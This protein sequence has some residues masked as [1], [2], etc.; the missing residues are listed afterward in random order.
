MGFDKNSMKLNDAE[1]FDV[2]DGSNNNYYEDY[3]FSD[4]EGST[5]S[6]GLN[7]DDGD[8]SLYFDAAEAEKRRKK[9]RAKIRAQKK[10][11]AQEPPPSAGGLEALF[12]QPAPPPRNKSIGIHGEEDGLAPMRRRPAAPL[13]TRSG[14]IMKL[15]RK[16][17]RTVTDAAR[18]VVDATSTV[19]E[20][21][22]SVATGRGREEEAGGE[23]GPRSSS[24]GAL[25]RRLGVTTR[26]ERGRERRAKQGDDVGGG[27][28]NLNLNDDSPKRGGIR[29]SSIGA[30]ARRARRVKSV[31]DAEDLL[32]EN[33]EMEL[34]P[35]RRSPANSPTRERKGGSVSPKARRG[36]RWKS[37]DDAEDL[38]DAD[39]EFEL[40]LDDAP[41]TTPKVKKKKRSNSVGA[42]DT[43]SR[44]ERKKSVDEPTGRAKS[45]EGRKDRKARK[46]KKRGTSKDSD[47]SSDEGLER[48]RRKA[49]SDK[50][51]KKASKSQKPPKSKKSSRKLSLDDDSDLDLDGGPARATGRRVG[52]RS[53]LG[54]VGKQQDEVHDILMR[55][56]RANQRWDAAKGE[57]SAIERRVRRR[58]SIGADEGV[59]R[60]KAVN[61]Q[62]SND[63]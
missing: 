9:E 27:L 37:V 60:P 31:D 19:A 48:R 10:K 15:N 6:H 32:N 52:R 40:K 18:T 38:L 4:G 14:G 33:G 62:Q 2:N 42:L 49:S 17:S 44:R 58:A 57:N 34:N 51:R 7:D 11:E 12:A 3:D 47:D 24:L 30:L 28:T 61:R 5:G 39:G 56:Q 55:T 36:E 23:R 46:A 1:M 29:G 20:V 59:A 45:R 54:D 16:I 63:L 35:N 26:S 8:D 22:T 53:S 41:K 50:P 13:R 25:S 21:A 43:K